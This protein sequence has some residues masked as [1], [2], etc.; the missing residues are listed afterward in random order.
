MCVFGF[1]FVFVFCFV[2]FC[3]VFF[4]CFVFV[5]VC[6]FCFVLFFFFNPS[7]N[8]VTSP[9]KNPSCFVCLSYNL[10]TIRL[11][12]SHT[13]E[14]PHWPQYM[15]SGLVR[16]CILV[17]ACHRKYRGIHFTPVKTF[18]RHTDFYTCQCMKCNTWQV[19]SFKFNENSEKKN[20]KFPG[21]SRILNIYWKLLFTS[22]FSC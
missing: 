18:D 21:S 17:S 11:C 3:F 22:C 13:N 1:V 19:F 7:L 16:F 14:K 20:E 12:V 15:D 4:V 8:C 9:F 5:F 6:V 10:G 2:L